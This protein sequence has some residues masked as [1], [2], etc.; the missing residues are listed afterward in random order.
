MPGSYQ[1]WFISYCQ[2]HHTVD[3][4]EMLPMWDNQ[5]NKQ[6]RENRALRQWTV[7]SLSEQ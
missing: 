4:V 2:E 6:T 3:F 7:G 5:T 1:I